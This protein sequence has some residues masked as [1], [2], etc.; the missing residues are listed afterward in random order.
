[1]HNPDNDVIAKPSEVLSGVR[2]MMD[3]LQTLENYTNIDIS[4]IFNN[5]LLQQTQPTDSFTG[6]PTFTQVIFDQHLFG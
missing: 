4:R 6:E 3:V 1:M 5:V 2:S